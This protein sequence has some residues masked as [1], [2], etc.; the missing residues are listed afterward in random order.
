MLGKESNKILR[1][2]LAPF[3]LLYSGTLCKYPRFMIRNSGE[4][5]YMQERCLYFDPCLTHPTFLST[6]SHLQTRLSILHC[7]IWFILVVYFADIRVTYS[8]M[9][10]KNEMVCWNSSMMMHDINLQHLWDGMHSKPHVRLYV[11]WTHNTSIPM[12][13]ERAKYP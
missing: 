3:Y 6:P 7:W 5:S 8:C 2:L 11:N 10:T 9:L 1:R 12:L 4:N 13:P